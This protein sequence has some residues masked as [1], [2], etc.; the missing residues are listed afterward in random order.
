M[1]T[2][3]R[4]AERRPDLFQWFGAIAIEQIESWARS[5][6][7]RV[8]RDLVE[9]WSQT[10]GG[11][12]FDSETIFRPT[13]IRSVQRYFIDGD[14]VHSATQLSIQNGMSPSYLAFHNGM[15]LSVVRLSD[16]MLVTLDEK[17]GE[18]GV[19]RTF[20]EWYVRTLHTHFGEYYGLV[21][22]SNQGLSSF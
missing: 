22:D 5:S 13:L 16:Q 3:L 17:Y 14:D 8:P 10:G 18:T 15:F 12:L 11:D 6:S 4:D 7:L 2:I 20:D 19:F 1:L 21:D 9:F